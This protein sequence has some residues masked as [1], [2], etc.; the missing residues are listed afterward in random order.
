MRD[1]G[2]YRDVVALTLRVPL[3][4]FILLHISA[5]QLTAQWSN[6]LHAC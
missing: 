4:P 1:M 3:N 2:P 5:Q 6:A